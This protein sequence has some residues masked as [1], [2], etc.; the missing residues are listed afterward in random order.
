MIINSKL[1]FFM[2][3]GFIP[4]SSREP[5]CKITNT[6]CASKSFKKRSGEPFLVS[7]KYF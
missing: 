5:L 2:H 3:N 7:I 6:M 4:E 1:M